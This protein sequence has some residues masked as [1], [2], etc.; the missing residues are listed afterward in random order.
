M[1]SRKTS[2]ETSRKKGDDHP[3]VV[4]GTV[5]G[6]RG[7]R[8]DGGDAI[9]WWQ[10]IRDRKRL[11]SGKTSANGEYR[12][13]YS[14]PADAPGKVLIVVEAHARHLE[15]P[16][17]SAPTAAQPDLEINLTSEP[18][19]VSELS[20]LMQAVV[21]LLEKLD[22]DDLVENEDHHDISFLAEETGKPKEDIVRLTIAARL[23]EA[24]KVPLAAFYAF[25]RL[26]V[27]TS[28]PG[29]LLDAA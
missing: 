27:P 14:P 2:D 16:I 24:Y 17:E 28:L 5:S 6:P 8:L 1:A 3:Y 19:D 25:L 13:S 21:P 10:R 26:R 12:L 22:L 18:H 7:E 11:A 15:S 29:P 4:H 9:V 20:L 23:A